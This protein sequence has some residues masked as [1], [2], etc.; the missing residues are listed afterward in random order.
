VCYFVAIGAKAPRWVLAQVFE[1]HPELDVG[2]VAVCSQ[3]EPVFPGSDEVILVTRRGCSCDLLGPAAQS[4]ASKATTQP[5][6]LAFQQGLITLAREVGSVRLIVH[7]HAGRP[8]THCCY[9]HPGA[10][11]SLEM[12]ELMKRERWFVEDVLIEVQARSPA[13][14][15]VS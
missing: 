15:L 2:K 9:P 12:A 4:S 11:I 5:L 6:A 10:R 13:R 7:R 3:V 1:E 14:H 8:G